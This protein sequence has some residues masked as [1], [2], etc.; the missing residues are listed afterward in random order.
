MARRKRPITFMSAR[1]VLT[2]TKADWVLFPRSSMKPI[3]RLAP[4]K[5]MF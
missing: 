4:R 3:P 2:L 5:E 1:K